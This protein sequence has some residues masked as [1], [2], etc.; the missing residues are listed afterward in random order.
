MKTID[1]LALP[2]LTIMQSQTVDAMFL[3]S[4]DP[5]SQ[6]R[7]YVES[8]PDH[9]LAA[10]GSMLLIKS[11]GSKLYDGRLT[12]IKGRGNLTWKLDKKPYQ[13]KLDKKTDLME[14]GSSAERNKTWVLLANTTDRSLQRNRIS[15]EMAKVLELEGTTSCK[16]VDLYYDGEYRGSYLLC[17]K[18]E[19]GTGRVEIEELEKSNENL[20]PNLETLPL[21]VGLNSFG[22]PIKYSQGLNNPPDI[23]GGYLFEYDQ[24][25]FQ[26]EN[27]WFSVHTKRGTLFFVSKS[28]EYWSYEQA[29]YL[30]CLMQEA[31]DCI[32]AGGI[33]A[34]TGKMTADYFDI[35]SLS[36]AM[37]INEFALNESFAYSSAYFT[38]DA[39]DPKIKSGPI[40]DFDLSY[41]NWMNFFANGQVGTYGGYRLPDDNLGLTLTSDTAFVASLKNLADTVFALVEDLLGRGNSSALKP[42]DEYAEEIKASAAMNDVLG[43]SSIFGIKDQ[44]TETGILT[45]W[46]SNR[47]AWLK[48]STGSGA[49]PSVVVT[50]H[51]AKKGWLGSNLNESAGTTGQSLP[52]EAFTA[53]LDYAGTGLGGSVL[54]NAHVAYI[55][56]QANPL[57]PGVWFSDGQVAG[58]SGRALPI[59]AVQF[60]LSGQMAD[61]YDIYYRAHAAGLGWMGW[62]KNG[63]KAGTEGRST[64]LEAVQVALVPKGS[65]APATVYLG[66]GGNY[67][68]AY[69][70]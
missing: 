30:S 43:W 42:L 51:V 45:E 9:T 56:W 49:A 7:P 24:A 58:T 18:I 53:Q 31:I 6:G 54:Y 33:N 22:M 28:P 35:E 1:G 11:D 69:L 5:V 65:P 34:T 38:K 25:Y 47:L 10:T 70:H 67:S 17:E 60:Q 8:S 68:A 14:S 36:K 48:A 62:A 50:P 41:G 37:W 19:I 23:T 40:W 29:N 32:E 55:G 52:L 26:A 46:L 61:N 64:P 63:E 13:I 39:G 57:Q 4:D 3:V 27:A 2:P 20:N 12:Q 66:I 44:A 59:E 15:L 16:P 21:V